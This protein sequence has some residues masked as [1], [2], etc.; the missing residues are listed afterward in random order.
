MT[1]F[2]WTRRVIKPAVFFLCLLPILLLAWNGFTGNLSANPI[3]DITNATG[4]WTLRLLVATLMITP[5]RRLSGWS[6]A[7]RLRRMVGLFVFFYVS[8][9]FT[10]YIYLDKFFD[11]QD[12]LVDVAKRPF[13]TVGFASFVLMIPLAVTSNDRLT[14]KLGGKRWQMLHR[15]IYLIAIGGVVHYTW[16]LK[17][18]FRQTWVYAAIVGLLLL[19]RL[20]VSFSPK[21]I[22]QKSK[23]AKETIPTA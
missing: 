23:A 18:G 6:G 16:R 15:L 9:H 19:Y 1:Q 8:L 11:L 12:M 5:L 17:T 10:T 7:T 4:I 13:I 3:A 14:R 22:S 21:L 2:D 20:W